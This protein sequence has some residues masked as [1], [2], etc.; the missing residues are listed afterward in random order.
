MTF[1][2][3]A[4]YWPMYLW[5]WAF[6]SVMTFW[7]TKKPKSLYYKD[8]YETYGDISGTIFL[9]LVGPLALVVLVVIHA[10]EG[11]S[12]PLPWKKHKSERKLRNPHG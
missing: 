8:N 6:C 4:D 1:I 7:R 9:D 3:I 5:L 11:M 2:E 10:L 12:K